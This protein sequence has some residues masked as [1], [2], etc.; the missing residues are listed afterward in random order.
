MTAHTGESQGNDLILV[1]KFFPEKEICHENIPGLLFQFRSDLPD[2]VD[3]FQG[4]AEIFPV[5]EFADKV[6]DFDFQVTF[7]HFVLSR[8][9]ICIQQD[10]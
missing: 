8:I 5:E 10:Y 9:F 1:F 6:K 7:I 2:M 3:G 4:H